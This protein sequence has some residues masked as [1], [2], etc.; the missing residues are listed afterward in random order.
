MLLG[1]V[2]APNT[3]QNWLR[4][5]YRIFFRYKIQTKKKHIKLCCFLFSTSLGKS[6]EPVSGPGPLRR[7]STP[8]AGPWV[9]LWCCSALPEWFGDSAMLSGS[10]MLANSS[11][12]RALDTVGYILRVNLVYLHW[13]ESKDSNGRFGVKNVSRKLIRLTIHTRTLP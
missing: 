3:S 13:I 2:E 5:W 1:W 4:K 6:I 9:S 8:F 11:L 10:K 12:S 7:A